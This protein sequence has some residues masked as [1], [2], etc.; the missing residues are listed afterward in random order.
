MFTMGYEG[1]MELINCQS[2]RS[3]W[4][5]VGSRASHHNCKSCAQRKSY[6]TTLSKA[7]AVENV[8]LQFMAEVYSDLMS[9]KGQLMGFRAG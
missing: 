9:L 8:L 6:V 3:L 5:G 4:V 1:R 7:T 2:D